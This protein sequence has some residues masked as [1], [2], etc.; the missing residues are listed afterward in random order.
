MNRTSY[1]LPFLE[2]NWNLSLLSVSGPTNRWLLG[3]Q[4][5][6]L[7]ACVLVHVLVCC[8]LQKPMIYLHIEDVL[9]DSGFQRLSFTQGHTKQCGQGLT[10]PGHL[11][12]PLCLHSLYSCFLICKVA[13]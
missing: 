6:M 1:L 5:E 8:L 7:S 4:G 13:H 11:L 2:G 9:P 10:Q 3:G 12:L